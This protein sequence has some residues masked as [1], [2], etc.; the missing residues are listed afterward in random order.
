MT[1]GCHFAVLGGDGFGLVDFRDL[2]R[3]FDQLGRFVVGW[4][5]GV[6]GLDIS[7]A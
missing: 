1:C 6:L 4:F 5:I 7:R 3:W 2:L